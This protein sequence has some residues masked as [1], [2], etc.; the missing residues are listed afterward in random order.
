MMMMLELKLST[1]SET[2][3]LTPVSQPLQ[4]SELDS[5]CSLV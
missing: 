1:I 4:S 2:P 5:P 3:A